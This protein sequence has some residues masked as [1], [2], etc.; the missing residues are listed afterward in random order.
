MLGWSTNCWWFLAHL[1][2]SYPPKNIRRKKNQ[3]CPQYMHVKK[4]PTAESSVHSTESFGCNEPAAHPFFINKHQ[5][6]QQ[7]VN[8]KMQWPCSLFTAASKWTDALKCAWL[9]ASKPRGMQRLS[10]GI[11]FSR[12][13]I[14]PG[15]YIST[16]P[17]VVSVT[18]MPT[19]QRSWINPIRRGHWEQEF[20]LDE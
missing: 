15:G 10:T 11:C 6:T 7:S 4:H 8:H 9:F 14:H 17:L 20:V 13:W 19:Y 16:Q 1:K 5:T 2:I 12:W 3:R 18:R